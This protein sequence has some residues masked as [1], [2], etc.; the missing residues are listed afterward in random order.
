MKNSNLAVFRGSR[1]WGLLGKKTPYED[2]SI[3]FTNSEVPY[4]YISIQGFRYP[5][6]VDLGSKLEMTLRSEFLNQISKY[7]SGEEC[8][9]NFKGHKFV[10]CNYKIP[11]F[12]IGSIKFK[13]INATEELSNEREDCVI[14]KNPNIKKR[15][16]K[17]VGSLGRALFVSM[18][19]LI[20]SKRSK[21]IITNDR[22]KLKKNGYDLEKFLKIPFTFNSKGIVLKVR[23]DLG[24][25][26]LLLDTGLT[27]TVL[28]ENLYPDYIEKCFDYRGLLSLNSNRFSIEK[29]NFGPKELCFINFTE[30]LQGVDGAIG[31]DF[32]KDHV[33]Y[34]DFLQNALYIE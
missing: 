23:T 3:N 5:M 15:G 28:H 27:S 25:S 21:M 10:R 12:Q 1:V 11:E 29:I 30:K 34:V 4:V 33:I 18:N 24:V 32:I 31:M 19:L 13:N 26:K 16:Q 14:W 8:W 2:L 6:K 22:K 7:P 20:D 17:T 9:K